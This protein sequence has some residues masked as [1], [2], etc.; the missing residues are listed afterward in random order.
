[1]HGRLDAPLSFMTEEEFD[2]SF[3]ELGVRESRSR[4][5][6]GALVKGTGKTTTFGGVRA[7]VHRV[8]DGLGRRP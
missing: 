5:R 6:W 7:D 3:R 1:M 8:L 4:Y 2:E